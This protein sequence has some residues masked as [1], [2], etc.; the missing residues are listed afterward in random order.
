MTK[1]EQLA[2]CVMLVLALGGCKTPDIVIPP[3]V[4][5][6]NAPVVVPPVVVTNAPSPVVTNTPPAVTTNDDVNVLTCV[7]HGGHSLNNNITANISSLKWQA[8]QC[9]IVYTYPDSWNTG[10]ACANGWLFE[11]VSQGNGLQYGYV[12]MLPAT[13]GT[14]YNFADSS[15]LNGTN[16]GFVLTSGTQIGL[17]IGN[18][19]GDRSQVVWTVM[20]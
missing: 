3:I 20:P 16:Y 14:G 1:T 9:C 6:T 10:G 8:G 2:M 19:S 7:Q 13:S 5:P 12:E 18:A 17:C 4:I 15:I 11:F